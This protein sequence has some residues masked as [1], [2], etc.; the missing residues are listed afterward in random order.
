MSYLE[1]KKIFGAVFLVALVMM[2]FSY[3]GDGLVKP[4]PYDAAKIKMAAPAPVKKAAAKKTPL[5]AI[6]PLL[7]SAS[8]ENGKAVF[9][10]CA[11]C[12]TTAKGDKKKIGPNLWNIVNSPRAGKA[13]YKYSEGMK[14]KS[15]N[16]TFES[17]NE[18]LVK[19]KAY[20][21]RTKMAFGGIKKTNQRADLILYLRSLADS[22][23]NLP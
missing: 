14:N 21:S 7:A 15:G 8:A 3:I 20:I 13:D 2:T 22:P 6:G 16:W 12:H 9:K 18:F 4:K 11:T 23:A 19:P 10:K 1:V 17:L 5:A